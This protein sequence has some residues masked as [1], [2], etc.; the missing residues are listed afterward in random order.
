VPRI[1]TGNDPGESRA[2]LADLERRAGE[3]YVSDGDPRTVT[4][5][6]RAGGQIDRE[7]LRRAGKRLRLAP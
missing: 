1:P 7:A 2:A 5:P 3:R 4:V 6:G